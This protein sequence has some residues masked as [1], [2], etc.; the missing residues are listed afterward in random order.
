MSRMVYVEWVP[1]ALNAEDTE[2]R[3]HG[4]YEYPGEA[5]FSPLRVSLSPFPPR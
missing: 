3:R 5:G 2:G 1:A 4:G